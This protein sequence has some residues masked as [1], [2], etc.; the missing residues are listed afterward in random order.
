MEISAVSIEFA[1]PGH[2]PIFADWS[3]SFTPGKTTAITGPSGKGKSTL[4]YLMGLMVQPQGGSINLDGV[5]V[6]TMPDAE[7]AAIRANHFGFVF[8]DALL[9]PSRTIFDNIVEPTLYRGAPRNLVVQRAT[10]L[11]NRFGVDH[12]MSHKPGEVSGGQAQRI[13]LCRALI[14]D[15]SI[16]FADEPTG[17]LDPAAEESVV[18]AL[19]EYARGGATVIIVTH[20]EAVAAACDER[21]H[22]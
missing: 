7:R 10:Q 8:Q 16:I 9:D 20:S 12:R 19:T 4:L 11:A 18:R 2:A 5:P 3:A 14:N 13:A 15:P 1:Y 6:S 17:N 22:L 21:L